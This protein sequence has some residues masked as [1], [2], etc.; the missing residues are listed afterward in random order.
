MRNKF[1]TLHTSLKRQLIRN[2]QRKPPT[3]PEML[4]QDVSFQRAAYKLHTEQ[5]TSNM[6]SLIREHKSTPIVTTEILDD[7]VDNKLSTNE[8]IE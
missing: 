5:Y 4:K 8:S 6:Q 7:N 3:S 1:I 2:R